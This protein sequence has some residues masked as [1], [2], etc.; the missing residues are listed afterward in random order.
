MKNI[1]LLGTIVFISIMAYSCNQD[2]SSHEIPESEK[3]EIKN[4]IQ[5]E[6]NE[7]IEA[8]KTKNIDLYMS[9]MP[10]DLVI[11]DDH[12]EIISKQK[13]RVY[14]LRDW[15][16][17]DTTLRIYATIDSIQYLKRDSVIVFTYQEW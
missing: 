4:I 6:I 16:I 15:S 11:L 2:K 10:D 7:G 5:Q 9:Q 3:A 8:T 17:I 13:Q 1:C 14:A 12:G